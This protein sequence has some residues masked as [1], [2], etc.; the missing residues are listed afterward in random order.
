MISLAKS[1]RFTGT[2]AP[3]DRICNPTL[4]FRAICAGERDRIPP[5]IHG[6]S[7]HVYEVWLGGS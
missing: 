6:S 4:G 2:S 7:G 1:I 5:N 3:G